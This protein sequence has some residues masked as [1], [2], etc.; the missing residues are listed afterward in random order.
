MRV[1][2]IAWAGEDLDDIE[3]ESRRRRNT[4]VAAYARAFPELVHML[5]IVGD[6]L[7]NGYAISDLIPKT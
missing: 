6:L 1:D 5:G 3:D 7:N 2:N 4:T